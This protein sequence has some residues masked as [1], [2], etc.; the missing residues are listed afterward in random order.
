MFLLALWGLVVV[1]GG[2]C[3]EIIGYGRGF[4]RNKTF[5]EERHQY[6]ESTLTAVLLPVVCVCVLKV[7]GVSMGR[8]TRRGGR[9][10]VS[11]FVRLYVG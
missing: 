3:W 1:V 6:F 2:E 7:G 9:R 8:E 11:W 10:Y 5:I 4:K